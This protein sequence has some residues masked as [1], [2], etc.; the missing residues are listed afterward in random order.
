M[1]KPHPTL[2]LRLDLDER[3]DSYDLRL[4][5]DRCYSYLGTPVIRTHEAGEGD[6]VNAMVC[7][8]RLGAREYLDSSVP[9]ADELWSQC[10]EHWLLN[11]V[12]AVENHMKIFN[13][14]QRE[15]GRSELMFDWLVVELQGG[16]LVVKLRLDSLCGIDPADSVWVSR[17]REALNQGLLGDGVS[18]VRLPSEASYRAQREAGIAA[19]EARRAE[20]AQ[21]ERAAR[22]EARRRAEEA[23]AQAEEAFLA[24]PALVAQRKER[25]LLEEE[26]GDLVVQARIREDLERFDGQLSPE[27]IVARRIAEEA[28]IGEDIQK[29]YALPEADFA[30]RFDIWD[31]VGPD[32]SVHEFAWCADNGEEG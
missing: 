26:A 2:A 9:G 31:V 29:K 12:H 28:H 24:S 10:I 4:E 32:G 1:S 22:E 19:L 3:V 6:P 17:V 5:I 30:V 18:E 14:R 23:E 21:A 8:V 25:E 11:Q 27:E 7:T 13:R 15:E 16:R 20:E